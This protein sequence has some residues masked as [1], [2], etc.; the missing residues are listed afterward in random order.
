MSPT[1]P[2]SAWVRPLFL[3]LGGLAVAVVLW[4][5]GQRIAAIGLVLLAL[6]LAYWTAPLRRGP[7]TPLAE[8]LPR[9]AD[10]H[11]V[12]LWAPGDTFSARL[13]TAVRGNRPDVTWVNVL[14]DPEA[15]EFLA[16]HGGRSAL[17]LVI[18]GEEVLRHA[19]TGAYLDA[20]AA[21]MHRARPHD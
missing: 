19:T 2:P 14:Q 3:L 16:A 11:A 17:P 9:V 21:G 8:A 10:D 18:V 6:L 13:Q 5:I 1:V 7:H 20:R 15:A 12:I 4:L